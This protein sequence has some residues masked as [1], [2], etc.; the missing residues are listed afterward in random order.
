MIP[1]PQLLLRRLANT[2]TVVFVGVFTRGSTQRSLL[3]LVI[4]CVVLFGS[5]LHSP[6]MVDGNFLA[7]RILILDCFRWLRQ[8]LVRH[9]C[10][11]CQSALVAI[12]LFELF[13]DTEALP[14]FF[15]FMFIDIFLRKFLAQDVWS[16]HLDF[17]VID[18]HWL[19][20]ELL[21]RLPLHSLLAS[22]NLLLVELHCLFGF[23][24]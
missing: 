21:K 18:G 17:L 6:V 5:L 4:T 13:D 16:C 19:N 22:N 9:L 10:L 11:S 2:S 14:F 3:A 12:E 24:N 15:F 7:E 20:T 1:L 8:L 23:Q